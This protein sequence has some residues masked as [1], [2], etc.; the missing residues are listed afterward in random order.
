MCQPPKISISLL[1]MTSITKKQGTQT[2]CSGHVT[3][4]PALL[5][6][7]LL[8]HFP[9]PH[10]YRVSITSAIKNRSRPARDE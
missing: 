2:F 8:W 10:S 6:Y 1:C 9:H 7:Q 3:A 4:M 5:Q